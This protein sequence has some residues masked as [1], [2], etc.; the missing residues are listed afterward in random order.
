MVTIAAAKELFC[1]QLQAVAHN[2]VAE[3]HCLLTIV[4]KC[5]LSKILAYPE[6]LLS[7][8]ELIQ[9]RALVDKRSTG[10]PMAYIQGFVDFMGQRF[11][12]NAATLIPRPETETMVLSILE[13]FSA[14]Q[15]LQVVDVGTGSGIIALSLAQLRP[16][17]QLKA[18][19]LCPKALAVA[20]RN[21]KQLQLN[22][23][24]LAQGHLLEPVNGLVDLIV[25]NPPYV[26]AQEQEVMNQEVQFEPKHA[27]F[28]ED[29]GY[30]LLFELAT[31][32][33]DKLKSG[34]WLFM[35]H[36]YLQQPKLC[37]KLAELG[38]QNITGHQ[39]LSGL[40]RFVQAQRP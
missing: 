32:A 26:G 29:K 8:T 3:L 15:K 5:E 27:L 30:R 1:G 4:K 33:W 24:Q 22:D 18:L 36:G 10:Y 34:G 37:Q 17:W 39:D 13:Q 12:V 7:K 35:E 14:Q 20:R 6:T 38:Y 40:Q 21:V 19:D 23:V 9:L 31:T 28:A 16:N 25:S 2:P 11:A